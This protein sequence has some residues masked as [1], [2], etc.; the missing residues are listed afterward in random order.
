MKNL[1]ILAG[2]LI[3]QLAFAQKVKEKDVPPKVVTSLNKHFK[4]NKKVSWEQ[5]DSTYIAGF[6][7]YGKAGKASFR[8]KGRLIDSEIEL[9]KDDL[10]FS[11]NHYIRKNYP[12]DKPG[13]ILKLKN[14]ENVIRYKVYLPEVELL[15]DSGGQFIS[16]TDLAEQSVPEDSTGTDDMQEEE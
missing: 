3:G 12:D 10:P 8:D 16:K 11:V 15:F 1:L 13:K 6:E 14:G 4:D 7:V 5:A 9:A 2:L